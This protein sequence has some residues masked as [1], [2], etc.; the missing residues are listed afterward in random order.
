M[1]SLSITGT[2][3][4]GQ[5]NQTPNQPQANA[6]GNLGRAAPQ[7]INL[8]ASANDSRGAQTHTAATPRTMP[9]AAPTSGSPSSEQS[10]RSASAIRPQH[11]RQTGPGLSRLGRTSSAMPERTRSTFVPPETRQPQNAPSSHAAGSGIEFPIEQ[12]QGIGRPGVGGFSRNAARVNMSQRP[13]SVGVISLYLPFKQSLISS[14]QPPLNWI[15]S[16]VLR[17]KT[18][19]SKSHVNKD[20]LW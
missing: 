4:A 19:M 12:S 8:D 3:G 15:P 16:W 10:L 17:Q 6:S 13:S 1:L 20:I 18:G 11:A 14:V 9:F 7:N 5:T 2:Q